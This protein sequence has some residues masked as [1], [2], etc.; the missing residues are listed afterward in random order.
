MEQDHNRLDSLLTELGN[1]GVDRFGLIQEGQPRHPA[2]GNDVG[3]PLQ[4]QA[5]E[6]HLDPLEVADPIGRKY[7]APG[8]VVNDIGCEELEVRSLEGLPV[9]VLG[10]SVRSARP[11][12]FSSARTCCR[13]LSR[14]LLVVAQ[15]TGRSTVRVSRSDSP[16]QFTEGQ[17]GLAAEG[18]VGQH[19]AEVDAGMGAQAV[20]HPNPG[21]VAA[22]AGAVQIR[23]HHAQPV[24]GSGS[25]PC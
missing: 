24:P 10:F 16:L 19:Q 8:P 15:R 11:V 12:F 17:A 14:L 9:R 13:R 21:L 23:V 6:G 18:R 3:S 25:G 5:D 2:A 7:R 20:V 22:D 1:Q 4:G